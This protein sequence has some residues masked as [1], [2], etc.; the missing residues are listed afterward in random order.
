[1]KTLSTLL[2][3]AGF[4]LLTACGGGGAS[5]QTTSTT[6][7]QELQDLEASYKKGIITEREYKN[8]KEAIL[9]RYD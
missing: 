3:A 2:L 4:I 7:G 6:M 5:V 1:M 9:E 8:A